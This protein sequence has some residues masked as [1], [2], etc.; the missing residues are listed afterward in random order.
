MGVGIGL[1]NEPSGWRDY[2][3]GYRQVDL[4]EHDHE[5]PYNAF[6]VIIHPRAIQSDLSALPQHG[7]R[8]AFDSVDLVCG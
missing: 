7:L 3:I 8:G 1:L 2:A 6:F 4:V 5:K